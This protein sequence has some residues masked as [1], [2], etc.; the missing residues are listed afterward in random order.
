MNAAG[1]HAAFLGTAL[2]ALILLWA[3]VLIGVS[4]L[5]APAKFAAPSLTLPVALDVGR[6]EFGTLNLVEIG[7]AVLTLALAVLTRPGRPI[8]LGLAIAALVVAAQALWLLP[9][10][11]ARA[12]LVIQGQTPQPAPWHTLYI[13]LEA[14]KLV[15]LL[16][17]GWLAVARPRVA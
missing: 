9:L 1:R 7:L 14:A 10:L 17:A 16:T 6:Q 8:W 13:V 15:A 5:A 2:G 11:D 4:F 12:L 3:G